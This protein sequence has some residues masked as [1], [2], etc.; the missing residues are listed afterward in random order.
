MDLRRLQVF[1]K[2]YECRSF[3]RAAEEVLLSQPTVSG[4]IKSLEDEIGV[5]LFDRLGR[6]IMPTQAALL[7]YEY[8]TRILGMVAE[9]QGAVDAFLGRMRGE[10]LVGGSTIPG[11][12][13]LPDLVGR[14]R[15]LHPE[16]RASLHIGDTSQIVGRVLSGELELGV[17]GAAA[18]DERLACTPLMQDIISVAAWP[19]HPLAGK[20]VSLSD[21]AQYPVVLREPGSGTMAFVRQALK[22]AG[23]N[24][25]DLE[26]AAQMSTTLAVIMAVRARVGLG[27]VS[28]R[29]MSDGLEA[30]QLVELAVDGL[31]LR[32]KFY[33]VARRG[34]THSPAAQA[35]TALCMAEL[36]DGLNQAA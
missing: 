24:L 34:R 2:V 9:A 30:G 27:F 22:K 1:S 16:V 7:L 19:G 5:Q 31:D 13:V 28:R 12:Y 6:E 36:H 3:S 18:D 8:S 25:D 29:A 4:H 23:V 15:L 26:A 20:P 10:L 21:L 33:L 11:H 17:V 14:F 32:R 35:F